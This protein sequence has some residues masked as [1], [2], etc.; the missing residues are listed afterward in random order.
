MKEQSRAEE[1]PDPQNKQVIVIEDINC[2]LDINGQRKKMKGKTDKKKKEE[3]EEKEKE[4]SDEEKSEDSGSGT[5]A[6]LSGILNFIDGLL[7]LCRGE[8]P[9]EFTTNHGEK[10]DTALIRS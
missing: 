7:S 10:L 8:R 4:E 5:I 9:I 2:S 6:T 1:V 3:E